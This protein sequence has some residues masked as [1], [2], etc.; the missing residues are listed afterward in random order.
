LNGWKGREGGRGRYS[1]V[2][3]GRPKCS[4]QKGREV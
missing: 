3:K 4:T 1:G 2:K